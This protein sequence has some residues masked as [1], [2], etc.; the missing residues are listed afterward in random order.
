M[1][2]IFILKSI[3]Y[4]YWWLKLIEASAG[5]LSTGKQTHIWN[6]DEELID[7]L[8]KNIAFFP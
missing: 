1:R 7:G 4:I 5:S 6:E 8:A 3:L 2:Y